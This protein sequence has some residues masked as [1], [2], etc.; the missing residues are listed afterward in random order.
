MKTKKQKGQ[1]F[2]NRFLESLTK[3]NP[4]TTI[5]FYTSVIFFFLF[6]SLKYTNLDLYSTGALY[7][8]GLLTWTLIEYFLHRF[9]FHIDDYLPFTKRFH[10]M[11]HGVH[12]EN[13]RDHERLFM[14]PVPGAIIAL[15]LF[16]FWYVFLREETFAFMAGISNGY[17]L[18]S[19]IHFSVHTKPVYEPLRKLWKN[20]ALHHFKYSDKAF[21]VSSP[22]WDIIFGTMPPKKDQINNQER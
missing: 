2:N 19:Y 6:M 9:I 21:G 18:Y 1:I 11:V 20:H 13:P 10:Y 22:L 15:I 3:S 16:T 5:L 17:L 7:I 14:P 8:L 12:H 4:K